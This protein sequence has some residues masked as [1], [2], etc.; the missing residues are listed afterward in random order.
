MNCI[1]VS[2]ILLLLT[3]GFV[4]ME[5]CG[6]TSCHGVGLARTRTLT[7]RNQPGANKSMRKSSPTLL[8]LLCLR[9]LEHAVL[10]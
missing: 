3:N 8:E 7:R 1:L 9:Y 10:F 6:L 5:R 2:T 4:V